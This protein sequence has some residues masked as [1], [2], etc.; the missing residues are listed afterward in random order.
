MLLAVKVETSP[1]FDLIDLINLD[2]AT[3]EHTLNAASPPPIKLP[4]SL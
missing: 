1:A 3:T 4:G 2:L